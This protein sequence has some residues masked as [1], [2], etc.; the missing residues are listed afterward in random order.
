MH[1]KD[2]TVRQKLFMDVLEGTKAAVGYLIHMTIYLQMTFNV[3]MFFLSFSAADVSV[4]FLSA[5]GVHDGHAAPHP[6]QTVER[7]VFVYD[8]LS[9]TCEINRKSRLL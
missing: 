5:S 7:F 3:L 2:D 9:F 8:W 4:C 1:L 6:P